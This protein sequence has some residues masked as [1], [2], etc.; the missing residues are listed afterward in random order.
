MCAGY[1]T[2]PSAVVGIEDEWLA[3]QFDIAVFSWGRHVNNKL[4]ECDSK[5]KPKYTLDDI[6]DGVDRPRNMIS[7]TELFLASG[8]ERMMG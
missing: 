7:V 4:A 2:R 1:G 5:G 3:Y 6:L 8:L